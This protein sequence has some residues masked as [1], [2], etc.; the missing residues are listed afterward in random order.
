VTGVAL[1]GYAVV[2]GTGAPPVIARLREA[3]D[4]A[5]TITEGDEATGAASSPLVFDDEQDYSLAV[6][7]GVIPLRLIAEAPIND[8]RLPPGIDAP[9]YARNYQR[10]TAKV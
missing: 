9:E 3:T 2:G 4:K 6:W 5:T 8:D 10:P 7:A 1:K